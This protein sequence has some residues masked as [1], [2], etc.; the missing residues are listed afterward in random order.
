MKLTKLVWLMLL[1]VAPI[2]TFAQKDIKQQIISYTD[3]TEIMIRNGRKLV[4]DKTTRGDNRG[5]IETMNYLKNNIDDEYIIFYPAEELLIRLANSDFHQFLYIAAHFDHLLDDKTKYITFDNIT[6]QIHEFL[7]QEIKLI[8][9]DLEQSELNAESK[10]FIQLYVRYYKGEDNNDL[11]KSIKSFQKSYPG[12]KF[13]RFLDLIKKQT[14]PAW[15][16]FCLG[17]G[18]EYLGG[19]LA[20]NFNPDFQSMAFELEWFI[21]QFYLSFFFQGSVE[22]LYSTY[23]MPVTGYNLIHTPEDEA[24]SIK[25]GMKLGKSWVTTK[26]ISFFSYLSIGNYQIKSQKSN[27]D[28]PDEESANLKLTSVFS[29]GIGTGC[30]INL[31]YFKN[32]VTGETV[33]KWFIRPNIGYDFFITGKEES[34]GG[35][36]F[37]NLSMGFGIGR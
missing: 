23:T 37:V 6:A 30:D 21:N 15:M 26:S 9:K 8:E 33:G 20:Q 36:L 35:S 1:V 31:K 25:Y 17:Y 13:N 5:A 2:L 16:N 24:F 32:K 7:S 10:E 18:H 12:S 34:K 22:K 19:N 28:I 3:S 27:F 11:N 4:A 14:T 29:P